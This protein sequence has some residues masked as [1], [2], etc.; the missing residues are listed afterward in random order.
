MN[1]PALEHDSVVD[2]L[3]SD[4]DGDAHAA[5][6]TLLSERE[7]LL[8]ELQYVSIAMGHG[9]ARGWKPRTFAPRGRS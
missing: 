4:H 3:I 2:Q 7:L 8:K 5:I 6:V 1:E 9:F